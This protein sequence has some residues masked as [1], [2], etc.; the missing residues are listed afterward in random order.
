MWFLV[1]KGWEGLRFTDRWVRRNYI[2]LM[3]AY[4]WGAGMV[5]AVS[6]YGSAE[7]TPLVV[8]TA[9]VVPL[10]VF[11]AMVAADRVRRFRIWRESR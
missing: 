4:L 7:A 10:M 11:I 3:I 9:L 5:V 8:Q 1:R 2:D 6:Y